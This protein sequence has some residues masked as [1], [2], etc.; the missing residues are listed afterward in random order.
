MNEKKYSIYRGFQSWQ[1]GNNL[2]NSYKSEE[3]M[4]QQLLMRYR[5][6]EKSRELF[7]LPII[8]VLFMNSDLLNSHTL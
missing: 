7:L 2:L 4:D 6:F 8:L 5:R 1:N 3:L